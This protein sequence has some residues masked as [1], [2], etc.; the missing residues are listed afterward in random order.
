MKKYYRVQSE[1]DLDAI[2][3]NVVNLKKIINENTKFMAVLKAD[4]YGHGAVAVA[5]TIDDMGLSSR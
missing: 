4:G 5:K 3:E 2:Y 1:I